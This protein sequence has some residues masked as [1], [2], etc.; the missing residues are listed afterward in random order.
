[1]HALL[2]IVCAVVA[3]A[4]AP[5]NFPDADEI[6]R[7]AD[8]NMRGSTNYSDMTMTVIRPDWSRTVSM[9]G[10]DKGRTYSLTLIT[11]PAKQQGQA[12]L[13]RGVE[14]WN[15]VPAIDRVIKIPPSMMSQS[16]M[17]SD[18]TNDDL[19]KES[20]TVKDYSHAVTGR[21]TIDG[22]ACWRVA[23]APLANAA[24][25]W[26]KVV[27]WITVQGDIEVKAEYYDEDGALVNTERFS[28]IRALGGRT[29][30]ARMEMTPAAKP[31]CKTV[32][33]IT[34]I[35]FDKPIADDFFSLQN[36]KR[37]R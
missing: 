12:F 17:G 27:A 26:G 6:V 30:P 5:Q 25:V 2:L 19:I 20:S 31:G 22:R 3:V 37:A 32:L 13:K 29:I 9:K 21:D 35:W 33:A 1:L 14:M 11:A 36:L 34:S 16:W 18:F 4:P 10:W 8:A 7:R 24:V 28:D 15:W 23:L